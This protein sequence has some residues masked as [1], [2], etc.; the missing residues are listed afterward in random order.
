[1]N[2]ISVSN[3]KYFKGKTI[4]F[5]IPRARLETMAMMEKTEKLEKWQVVIYTW[6]M[7]E[8]KVLI[9]RGSPCNS[10]SHFMQS[11]SLPK[12]QNERGKRDEK[13]LGQD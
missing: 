12:S 3:F 11:V 2:Y 9:M 6:F 10:L 8:L 1:M 4:F 7:R 5:F 13:G